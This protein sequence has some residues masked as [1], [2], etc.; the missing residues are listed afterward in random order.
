MTEPKALLNFRRTL[1][2]HRPE[3]IFRLLSFRRVPQEQ[4]FSEL[5]FCL[6]TPQ[7]NPLQVACHFDGGTFRFPPSSEDQHSLSGERLV[8]SLGEAL[9]AR[10][11]YVRF[12]RR[13]AQFIVAAFNQR[14]AIETLLHSSLPPVILRNALCE[15]VAGLG[16]KEASHCL[17]NMGV[18]GLAILD[19]HILRR[20]V[21]YNVLPHVPRSVSRRSYEEI[22]SRMKQFS[23]A[24]GES[25]DLIDLVLW[26][27]GT[28]L[29]FK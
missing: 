17:R 4:Y 24:V 21:F 12:H 20:L 28:G 1:E 16:M 15:K 27:E 23:A 25:M 22:E 13:K 6:L 14:T 3:L 8:H 7:T 10:S 11:S 19:R 5:I 9:R 2:R 18:Q 26:L 29:I